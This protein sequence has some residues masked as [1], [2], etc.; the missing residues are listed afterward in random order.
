MVK[1]SR[2]GVEV[3]DTFET[4]P[5]CGN[6]LSQPEIE[7]SHESQDASKCHVCG[8]EIKPD[9]EFCSKC[10]TKV[11]AVS[12]DRCTGCGSEIPEGVLFCPTCGTKIEQRK[13]PQFRRCP[14]CGFQLEEDVT[15]CPECGANVTTGERVE[16]PSQTSQDSNQSFTDK[17]NFNKIIKPTGVAL[18]VSI[19]LSIIGVLIGFS[20]MSFIIAII[21][22]MGFIGGLIDNDANAM[23]CGFFV[24]LILGLLE[25]PIIE[26][27]WG[28]FAA[29]FYEWYFGGQILLLIIIG[30]VVAYISNVYLKSRIQNIAGGLASWF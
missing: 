21:L 27:C 3:A 1:C 12:A 4:C 14:S 29:R 16:S 13:V 10:G 5:N 25:N 2:C 11:E 7:T 9:A 18:L 17:I 24:G 26:F 6:N 30:V 28:T 19:L 15:F 22:V 23:L 8:E 20:W